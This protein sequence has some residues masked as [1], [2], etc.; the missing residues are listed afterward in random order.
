MTGEKKPHQQ[1]VRFLDSNRIN[2]R[3]GTCCRRLR[4][5]HGVADDQCGHLMN[6]VG[7]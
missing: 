3:G 6:D 5:H 4:H 7:Y 1:A 2:D